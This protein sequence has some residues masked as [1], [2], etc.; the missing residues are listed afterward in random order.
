MGFSE[1]DPRRVRVE[2][3]TSQNSRNGGGGTAQSPSS[4]M[5]SAHHQTA[6]TANRPRKLDDGRNSP[7]VL[8]D[9]SNEVIPRTSQSEPSD[10]LHGEPAV[11]SPRAH[12]SR[13]DS[14]E[15]QR[16]TTAA[17]H[18]ST[19]KESSASPRH[20]AADHNIKMDVPLLS[21]EELPDI[22][23]L[24]TV[25]IGKRRVGADGSDGEERM[26]T[27]SRTATK[28]RQSSTP[29]DLEEEEDLNLGATTCRDVAVSR[30]HHT[31]PP[32][33]SSSIRPTKFLP[34]TSPRL[35]QAVSASRS[36]GQSVH[37]A[38]PVRSLGGS[39]TL[40]VEIDPLARPLKGLGGAQSSPTSIRR[41]ASDASPTSKG[42]MGSSFAHRSSHLKKKVSLNPIVDSRSLSPT[43]VEAPPKRT[44]TRRKP[45]RREPSHSDHASEDNVSDGS[46]SS[47]GDRKAKRLTGSKASRT[48]QEARSSKPSSSKP[49]EAP[50]GR[51]RR[52]AATAAEEKLRDTVMPDLIQYQRDMKAG[53]GDPKRFKM[54]DDGKASS[55]SKKRPRNGSSAVESDDEEHRSA[56]RRKSDGGRTRVIPA[57]RSTKPSQKGKARAEEDD[58][59]ED[60]DEA[61][62]QGEEVSAPVPIPK[63]KVPKKVCMVSPM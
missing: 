32:P 11:S 50:L 45:A 35:P 6:L 28:R 57:P 41:T 7:D 59:D 3:P 60:D 21:Q 29:T 4:N 30:V 63:S 8:N 18:V 52:G 61:S 56:Q 17:N 5:R 14:A 20:D 36:A 39:R 34:M 62:S 10:H 40:V 12:A 31:P 46:A 22:G 38:S 27:S 47:E 44:A 42:T 54:E 53:R 1:T 9:R 48:V 51:Q 43:E 2:L 24:G 58:D 26:A 13:R 25:S 19:P 37:G 55:S 33:S 16:P 49:A 23:G 15:D